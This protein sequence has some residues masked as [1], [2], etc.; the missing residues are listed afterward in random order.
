MLTPIS[1]ALMGKRKALHH[2][3]KGAD[4]LPVVLGS[5]SSARMLALTT[6]G[7]QFTVHTADIDEKAIRHSDPHI[8][9]LQIAKAKATAIINSGVLKTAVLLITADQVIV[10]PDGAVREK[11]SSAEEAKAFLRSYRSAASSGAAGSSADDR[12]V[13]CVSAVVVTDTSTG[14]SASDVC[15]TKIYYA[16]GAWTDEQLQRAVTPAPSVPLD[17]LGRLF[18]EDD[19]LG[20]PS[21]AK[22]ARIDVSSAAAASSNSAEAVDVLWCAGAVCIEHPEQARHIRRID[23]TVDGVW[24]MP[25][26]LTSRLVATVTKGVVPFPTALESAAPTD[27]AA[28]GDEPV[29]RRSPRLIGRR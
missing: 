21:Q 20:R 2:E 3:K 27:A 26:A 1:K 9:P 17:E 5:A 11:P 6:A 25:L 4:R 7:V 8:L 23:G 10:G 29:A 22:R 13:Q 28:G 16:D 19:G 14:E 12:F 18:I 15:V 24:G